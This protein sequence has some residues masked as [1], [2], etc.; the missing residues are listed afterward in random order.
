MS[1]DNTTV[2]DLMDEGRR[3]ILHVGEYQDGKGFRATIVFEGYPFYFPTGELTNRQDA[4]PIVWWSTDD[5]EAASE[6]A[7]QYSEEVLEITRTEHDRILLS[8][9]GAFNKGRRV[10]V[11]RDPESGEVWLRNGFD[12]ELQLE[13]DDAVALYQ[14]LARSME[15]PFRGNC[16]ECFRLLNY[17]DMCEACD[18]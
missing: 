14:D 3:Y 8:S 16:S 2:G 12:Q 11:K 13:E 10:T 1:N 7:Y 9:F 18:Y 15:L 6:M 4:I 17:D 5:K